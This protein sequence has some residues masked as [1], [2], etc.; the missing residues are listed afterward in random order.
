MIE[1]V[2]RSDGNWEVFHA[3]GLLHY[4]SLESCG[5]YIRRNTE[6]IEEYEAY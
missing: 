6:E 2:K 3:G 1:I 5:D 4:G